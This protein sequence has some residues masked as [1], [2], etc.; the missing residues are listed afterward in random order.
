[1][2]KKIVL[3]GDSIRLMG[4]GKLVEERLSEDFKIWQP[5][6]NCRFAKHTLRGLWD[7]RGDIAGADVVHWNNG[8]WDTCTLFGDGCFTPI[9]TYVEEVTR[10]ARLLK[11]R[12]RVVIFA[13]TTPVRY[14][15]AQNKNSIIEEYNAAVIPA[16][17]EMG[18][19]IN[20]LYTPMAS[21]VN[22]YICD[23]KIHLSEDGIALAADM[24]ESIIRR[25]A[26]RLA[27]TASQE[28]VITYSADG[29]PV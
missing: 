26:A 4:Y 15:N 8:L 28:R 19:V 7:W 14:D 22:R 12:A 20:D 2:K 5:D 6:T 17:S 23:D 25:E 27:D 9:D 10:L 3:L 21:D 29:A 13:T 16:L 11:E 1:M 18:V 24:V